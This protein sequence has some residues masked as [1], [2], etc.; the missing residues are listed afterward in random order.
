MSERF[1]RKDE[2]LDRLAELINVAQFVSFLPRPSLKQEFARVLGYEPNHKFSGVREAVSELLARSPEQSVNVRS[3]A[4][5]DTQSH[6]FLYGLNDVEAVVGSLVRISDSGLHVIVNETVDVRDGGVSGVVQSG[7]IEFSPDDTPRCVE[8]PGIASMP[9]AW[10]K[11]LL[12]RV[13]GFAIDFPI[14]RED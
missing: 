6:E 9:E 7:T 10:G 4:P 5:D 12:S 8:K 11:A 2:S 1:F 13:Y 3:F 14:S